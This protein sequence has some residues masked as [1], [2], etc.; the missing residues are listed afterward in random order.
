MPLQLGACCRSDSLCLGIDNDDETE[1]PGPDKQGIDHAIPRFH[2]RAE[3][4]PHHND[5]EHHHDD[6][7]SRLDIGTASID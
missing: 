5:R 3:H 7:P 6:S 4:G 2:D 1:R